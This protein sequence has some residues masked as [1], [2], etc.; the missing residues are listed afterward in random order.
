[1]NGNYIKISRSILDW[2]WYQNINTCRVFLHMLLKANWKDARFEGKVVPRGSF[3][4][5]YSKLAEECSLT[6]NEVRTAVKHLISTGEITSK[7]H[8]KFSVFTVKNYD[9]YQEV[10]KQITSSSQ[11]INKQLTTI[12]ERKK[13]IREEGNKYTCA[14]E[15]LWSAYPRRKEKAKAYKCYQARLSDGFSEDELLL[16]VKRYAQ[17]CE[18]KKTEEQFIKLAA[19]FLG[20][21]TPFLDFLGDYKTPSPKK[22][23]KF[24]NFEGRNYDIQSLEQQLL[25]P[26]SVSV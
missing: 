17:E 20:P 22:G 7:P 25:N 21:N 16:A 6:I 18:V 13:E 5:S 11:A 19:T 4:S 9:S 3:I 2:E 8:A 15:S 14:F 26:G 12:E 24:N 10:N 1:M 23:N